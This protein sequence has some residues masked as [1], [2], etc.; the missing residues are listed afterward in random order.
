[1]GSWLVVERARLLRL[2]ARLE[3][4]G[5][6]PFLPPLSSFSPGI[7]VPACSAASSKGERAQA[8]QLN[9]AF[10]RSREGRTAWRPAFPVLFLLLQLHPLQVLMPDAQHLLSKLS[11]RHGILILRT[12]VCIR[13]D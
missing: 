2:G 11:L 5:V 3:A 12:T 4:R 9:T 10:L 1:M 8:I 6:P 7:G 13:Q